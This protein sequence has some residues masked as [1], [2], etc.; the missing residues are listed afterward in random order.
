MGIQNNNARI[1]KKSQRKYIQNNRRNPGSI[2]K[3][4]FR[5]MQKRGDRKLD[6][7]I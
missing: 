5:K 7:P 2:R 6:K 1:T 4:G 3:I